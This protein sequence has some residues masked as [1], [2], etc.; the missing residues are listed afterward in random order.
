MFN[1][2]TS[3]YASLFSSCEK[4][5]ERL[6]VQCPKPRDTPSGHYPLR[7][8][9]AHIDERLCTTALPHFLSNKSTSPSQHSDP[10]YVRS[11]ALNNNSSRPETKLNGRAPAGCS[12]KPR[13][14][15]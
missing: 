7:G 3:S 13:S 6:I 15:S 9:L 8:F 4:T 10:H 2:S 14:V 5:I 11:L 12:P 1:S